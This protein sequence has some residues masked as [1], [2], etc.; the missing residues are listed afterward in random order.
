MKSKNLYLL[1]KKLLIEKPGMRNSDKPLSWRIWSEE[2]G[3][4]QLSVMSYDQY[5]A[6]TPFEAIS[7][8][9]RM[10]QQDNKELAPT[11]SVSN[12]RKQKQSTKG[13]FA[14]RENIRFVGN[15]AIITRDE[16]I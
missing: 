6:V 1:I 13:T 5:L 10:V 16:S 9:R 4:T 8:A 11:E 3:R 2:L 15:T 14:Y 7:R 12:R